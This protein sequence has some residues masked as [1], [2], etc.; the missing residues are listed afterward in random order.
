ML[1]A[2]FK[3]PKTFSYTVSPIET[4]NIDTTCMKVVP[5]DYVLG[6]TKVR[7]FV[8]FCILKEVAKYQS[9]VPLQNQEM[10]VIPESVKRFDIELANEELT[11]WNENDESLLQIIADKYNLEIESFFTY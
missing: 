11:N 10:K 6:A 2:K 5:V 9:S 7:F 1:Y 8:D 4:I 3:S